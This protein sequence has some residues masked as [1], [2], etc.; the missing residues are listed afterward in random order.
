VIEILGWGSDKVTVKNFLVACLV[1]DY[2]PASQELRCREGF[3]LHPFRASE[4]ITVIQ[5][6]EVRDANGVVTTPAVIASGVHFNLRV[7]GA[8]EQ[9]LI[10]AAYDPNNVSTA[11]ELWSRLKLVNYVNNKLTNVG[12]LQSKGATG[13]RIPM[14][15]EWVIAGKIIRLYD[16]IKVNNRSNVWA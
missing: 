10:D 15:Y 7:Y 12:A 3:S 8:P 16:A 14:G 6:P 13:A 11:G 5:T 1:A 9:A 4:D 2:D